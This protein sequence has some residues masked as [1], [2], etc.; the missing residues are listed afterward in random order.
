MEN[1]WIPEKLECLKQLRDQCEKKEIALIRYIG[2]M[3]RML[4]GLVQMEYSQF[5]FYEK[6][7]LWNAS[8][9]FTQQFIEQVK[10]ARGEMNVAKKRLLIDD[11]ENAVDRMTGVYKNVIDST[12]NSDR[13]ILSSISIDTSIYE[14]SPKIC[15]FY[16]VIL[17]RLVQMFEG[18]NVKY[19]FVLHPTLKNNTETQ[20]MFERR[21][22]SGK[23]VIIYISESIIEKFDVVSVFI[24]HEAFHVLTKAERM[25]KERVMSFVTLM[26]SGMRQELFKNVIFDEDTS[27]NKKIE[28]ELLG[29]FFFDIKKEVDKWNEKGKNDRKFYGKY[30]RQWGNGYFG[31]SLR[32]I[33]GSLEKWVRETTL[34]NISGKNYGEFCKACEREEL[35]INQIQNNLS[36]AMSVN[37]ALSLTDGFLFIFR[38]I[39]A[40]IACILTLQLEP[41]EYEKAF[42]ESK[43]FYSDERT[44][45]DSIRTVRNYIVA[46]TVAVHMSAEK[47]ALWNRYVTELSNCLNTE[48]MQKEFTGKDDKDIDAF[49]E[50]DLAFPKTC[51]ILDI[52]PQMRNALFEYANKCADAF[53]T[54]LES[55]ETIQS[56]RNFMFDV[57]R[58]EQRDW[59][60]KK[61]M[62]GDFEEIF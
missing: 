49:F 32:N 50:K 41:G 18:N 11:I 25:R 43:Q 57:R 26:L 28:D 39:Y 1:L 4:N 9:I 6:Q 2:C 29:K 16:S 61:I 58:R 47:N 19:A 17:N 30:I 3:I 62:I 34:G 45:Y 13:Q 10:A 22:K 23:V 37:T 15:A 59:I 27:R 33:N 38:E 5:H 48:K 51:V 36:N 7:I 56:F 21:Q 54:R 14:L 31:K 53:S 44:Y 46:R 40:D 42:M 24:L 55:V 8:E 60:M 35:V 20:I 52:T 12:A